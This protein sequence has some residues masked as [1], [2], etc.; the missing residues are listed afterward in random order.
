[1]E[2]E[3]KRFGFGLMRLPQKDG[4]ADVEQVKEMVDL[5]L[6]A[7]FNYFDTAWGYAGSEDAIREALVKRYPRDRYVLATKLPAWLAKSKE[8]AENMFTTSLERTQAG[9]FDYYLL[10]NMGENRSHYFDDFD[11]WNFVQEKQKEGLIKHWGFSFHDKA[12]ALE[13]LLSAHPEAEFV[14]L[15]I[16]YADWENPAIESRKCYETARKYGKQVIIMEPV[17]GGTL[18][19]PPQ[20]AAELLKELDGEK[21]PAYWALRYAASLEGVITVLSGMSNVEQMK[22]NIANMQT[23]SPLTQEQ[24]AKIEEAAE[25]IHS[26][27]SVPCTACAYCMKNC[28]KSVAIYGT[29]QALNQYLQYNDLQGAKMKYGWNTAGHGWGKASDCVKCGLCEQAC[30]Q[31]IAIREELKK[32]AEIL[33]A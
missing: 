30:P 26:T 32:A 7:G 12:D 31:H 9:Y 11:I 3:V 14:Q 8:E 24:R 13:E 16:N 27:P 6:E 5:F 21:S 28:S 10:H 25:V 29:F 1:M 33:E 15:Q 17:K 2:Q 20:K 23:F 22:D 4:A 19:N 18:A